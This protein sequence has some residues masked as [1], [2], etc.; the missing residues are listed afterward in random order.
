AHFQD[1]Y[2]AFDGYGKEVEKLN[3]I[4]KD[5][6]GERQLKLSSELL[7]FILQGRFTFKQLFSDLS[8][9]AENYERYLELPAELSDSATLVMTRPIPDQLE[10][11]APKIPYTATFF[12]DIF[13]P[14]T[15]AQAFVPDLI[16]PDTIFSYG[17]LE[18]NDNMDLKAFLRLKEATYAENTLEDFSI[19]LEAQKQPSRPD[20]S[21][22]AII[23]SEKQKLLGTDLE[24]LELDLWLNKRQLDFRTLVHHQT[25][26]D[27]LAL[28]GRLNFSDSVKVL[29]LYPPDLRV[30]DENW[31]AHDTTHIL[32]AGRE[33]AFLDS[34]QIANRARKVF[35]SGGV[36]EDTAKYLDV[37]LS[38]IDLQLFE[39]YVGQEV[40]GMAD[41]DLQLNRFYD[42]LHLEGDLVIEDISIAKQAFG[43]VVAIARWE[44]NSGA[45]SLDVDYKQR[46]M[47]VM[48]VVGDYFPS[49]TEDALDL[50]IAFI[51]LGIKPIEIFTE[52]I[53][54]ELR[55]KVFGGIKVKGMPQNPQL[56]GELFVSG[57]HLKMDYLG[58]R[59]RF[60]DDI[61]IEQD[62]FYFDRFQLQDGN[63]R[64]A[65]M[66]GG[67]YHNDF[68]DFLIDLEA[69]MND[70]LIL[71]TKEDTEEPYYGRALGT[72]TLTANGDFSYLDIGV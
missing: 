46:G 36:S 49:K 14:M 11:E 71:D 39:D 26:E 61:F 19:H 24:N 37:R 62:R 34:F 66:D 38:Q 9:L 16:V 65:Y 70:L 10:E 31:E 54:S 21:A 1:T 29:S 57:G 8:E 45:I 59:Y 20:I 41:L 4:A 32:W 47:N 13:D 69:E 64:V 33:I 55:G 52:G 72:G 42:T 43:S 40:R 18:V 63:G 23:R 28:S 6:N 30:L 60:D 67:L 2:L 7:D 15:F 27:S 22:E 3:L 5:L 44:E 53:V 58:T 50:D 35:L 25:S 68:S 48:R 51:G 12:L 17:R 56:N